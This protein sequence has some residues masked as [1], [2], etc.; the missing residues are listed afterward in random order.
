MMLKKILIFTLIILF[1]PFI[2]ASQTNSSNYKI[3]SIVSSGGDNISSSNYKTNAI[4]G[5]ITGNT[6]S[7]LYQQFL[8]FFFCTPDTC[9]S[10]GYDCDSWPDGCGGTLDCRTCGSGYTC[11]SGTCTAVEVPPSGNGGPGTVT[12]TYDWVCSEWYPEPCPANGI[13][14]RVC[15]NRGTCSGIIGI[16]SQERNCTPAI[17]LGPAE[18]LFDI[19][20]K[21]PLEKKWIIPGESLKVNIQ[22]INLGNTTSLDVFFKYWIVNENNTL[23]AEMQETRAIS[24][25]DKFQIE[26]LLSPEIKLGLYKFYVQI[27]YDINKVAIAED[28]FEVVESKIGKFV[29]ISFLMLIAF[30]VIA[31]LIWII[32]RWRKKRKRLKK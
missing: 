24:E 21:I 2:S 25:K 32:I 22:L 19:H 23:I 8:G 28:S 31:V 26:M 5:L 14:K 10:L 30:L 29:W 3:D 6:S 1:L 13:Q 18:P 7:S 27:T 20:A 11:T 15:V 16:P 12:C 4:L 17:P 9:A